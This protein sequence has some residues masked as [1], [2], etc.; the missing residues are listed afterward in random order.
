METTY[1]RMAS[2]NSFRFRIRKSSSSSAEAITCFGLLS[3][4]VATR[5]CASSSSCSAVIWMAAGARFFTC[6]RGGRGRHKRKGECS[7][8]GNLL[9]GNNNSFKRMEGNPGAGGWEKREQY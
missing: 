5:D 7:D 4:F 3:A 2:S 9:I 8:V 6:E 1:L